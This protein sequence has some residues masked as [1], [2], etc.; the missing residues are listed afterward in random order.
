MSRLSAPIPLKCYQRLL[1]ALIQRHNAAI[2]RVIRVTME[3]MS[4]SPHEPLDDLVRVL[5]YVDAID[6][7]NDIHEV[8]NEMFAIS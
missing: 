4:A 7:R 1:L 2:W 8:A 6:Q 3:V 5:G